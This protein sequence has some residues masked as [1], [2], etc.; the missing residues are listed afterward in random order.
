MKTPLYFNDTP[1]VPSKILCA[2]RN[3]VG[4]IKELGNA[5]PDSLVVFNKPPSA[6]SNTLHACLDEPL[7]YEAEL[8]FVVKGGELAGVGLGL[9]LTKRAL[10]TTLKNKGLPWERA[11]AFDGA[12][13]FSHFV[14]C[15][16]ISLDN[17]HLKLLIN[18]ELCQAGGVDLMLYSPAAI[19]QELASYTRL[20]DGDIIMT[21]TP[22]GVGAV[23]A[24]DQYTGEVYCR[25]Q[26][27][28]SGQWTAE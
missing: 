12:A 15:D 25:D 7:H 24:G 18:N 5:V 22:E 26:L 9:D 1:F 8:A 13:L 14:S 11:K 28:V 20:E 2:G 4:H 23:R 3:Y 19:V 17:L 10:Q 6:I 27:L 21:G 16:N